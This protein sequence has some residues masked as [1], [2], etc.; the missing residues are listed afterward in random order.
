MRKT[1]LSLLLLPLLFLLSG[2][3][4]VENDI[5]IND[6]FAGTWQNK[7]ITEVP[8][9]QKEIEK[10]LAQN[11]VTGYEIKTIQEKR[12]VKHNGQVQEKELSGFLITHKFHNEKEL[13][14]LQQRLSRTI[15][16]EPIAGDAITPD[17]ANPRRY[18]VHLGSAYERTRVTVPGKI[19]SESV[20]GG[21]LI[22]KHTA[23]FTH[24][25]DVAFQFEKE[26]IFA[27]PWLWGA[28]VFIISGA[29]YLFYRRRKRNGTQ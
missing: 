18:H 1:M 27:S 26:N 28:L 19:I 13:S 8:V 17:T 15:G 14:L 11:E 29:A 20:V 16:S 22:D 9:E 10:S 5:T 24:N 4:H 7:I 23:E 12:Q 6:D 21:Q 25:A 3:V 2:C